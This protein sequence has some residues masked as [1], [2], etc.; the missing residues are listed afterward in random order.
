MTVRHDNADVP[1]SP[2][3]LCRAFPNATAR[4]AVF[5]HGLCETEQAW[6]PSQ[7]KQHR[8]GAFNFGDHLAEIGF[9]PVYLRYNSGLHISDNGAR[10]STLLDELVEAWPIP[11]DE[12]ALSATR[13]AASWRAVPA[14]KPTVS[15]PAGSSGPATSS[16]WERHTSAPRWSAP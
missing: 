8:H 3:G 7:R 10:L 12:V 2:T 9:T 6:W 4:L 13:W 5:I 14:T 15:A 16:G 11:V 1:V